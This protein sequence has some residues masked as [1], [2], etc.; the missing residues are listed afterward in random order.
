MTRLAPT[1]HGTPVGE[2]P[3][4][5]RARLAADPQRPQYHFLPPA[6]WLNDPNGVIHWQGRYH[7]FYQYNP[8]GPFHAKIHW[9]HA[10]SSDLVHWT[11]LPVALAPTPGGPD[12]DG[13]WSGCAVVNDGVPTLI[14]TGFHDQRQL[15]C[16]ATSDD[17]MRTW[18]KYAG[19][20]VITAPPAGLDLIGFRDHSAW[21]EGDTWYQVIG[22]GIHGVGG[23]AL[24]YR[25]RD[26]IVWEYLQ[27]LCT[28]DKTST[29]PVWTGSMWECPDFFA[30]GDKHVL[31]VSV[32]DEGR[33]HYPA[34]AI[35]RYAGHRFTPERQGFVDFGRCFYAPQSTTDAQGRRVMWG[36]LREARNDAAQRAAGW[37]GVISLPRILSIRPDGALG[38][39]PASELEALRRNHRRWTALRVTP[40]A[41]HLLD[42][43]RGDALEIGAEWEPGGDATAYGIRLR[44]S[45]DNAEETLVVYDRGARRLLL[46]R[47]RSSLSADVL[48]DTQGGPL[49]L[50]DGEPL[51]LRIFLDRSVLEVY[52]NGRACLTERVYPTRADSLGL[53]LFA[54][55]GD[56]TLRE[57]N[58]WEMGSIWTDLLA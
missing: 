7:L 8:A 11:D 9:G 32:W 2:S 28:G 44:C 48:H 16:L 12:A 54:R 29:A 38:M 22:A 4:S 39:A 18:Q 5:V 3:A 19:N 15:P 13:C 31:T 50:A 43:V 23:A 21:K 51:Q 24:L 41:A 46:D 17:E 14:Y 34:Y 40:T 25:S 36:W 35:G 45:P 37:S 53:D 57:L 6:N 10:A 26:L 20:P 30:A 27:P 42:D 33:L 55:G 52:A 49:E 56:A 58:V 1:N 47:T